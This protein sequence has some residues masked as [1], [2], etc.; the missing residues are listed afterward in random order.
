MAIDKR[1]GKKGTSYRVSLYD[2]LTQGTKWIGTY[3]DELT[4]KQ[5]E[6]DALKRIK[7]GLPAVGDEN[8]KLE[9]LIEKWL[10]YANKPSTR[11]DYARASRFFL[12]HFGQRR[13]RTLKAE[14]FHRF[15]AFMNRKTKRDGK[16]YAPRV[17]RKVVTQLYQVVNFAV[18]LGYLD[19]SPAPK[20]KRLALPAE[21]AARKV[22][23]NAQQVRSLLDAA[24]DGW[25]LCLKVALVTGCR[26]G[27]IFNATYDAV[28]WD[29][30]ELEIRD[31]LPDGST[32]ALK[33]PA[34]DRVVPLTHSVV[35]G[36]R[37][38]MEETGADRGDLIFPNRDGGPMSYS[39]FYRRVWVP[40]AA[41]AGMPGLHLHDLRKAFAT[42]MAAA[43]RTNQYLEDVMGHKSYSTTMKYYVKV[44][45][46]EAD[47]A[48]RDLDDW[49]GQ[50]SSGVYQERAA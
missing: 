50:E 35:E 43:G 26:R 39:N 21:P 33:T 42:H 17:I 9:E 25:G 31:D 10:A 36:L 16:P 8:P 47:L 19:R 20:M 34:A 29:R 28:R 37:Q 18:E 2:P 13:I 6:L 23:L 38:R 24:P 49:L 30:M 40:T 12:E 41:K 22:R 44:P 3:H 46:E 32:G 48:R 4:A 45:E 15:V 14:D 5:A 27:E 1:E 11:E 7:S